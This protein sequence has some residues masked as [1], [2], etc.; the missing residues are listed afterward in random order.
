MFYKSNKMEDKK[1][2]IDSKEHLLDALDASGNADE[3]LKK[4]L[5]D[6]DNIQDIR[7]LQDCRKCFIREDSSLG[8]EPE[9][10]W[11][12]FLRKQKKNSKRVS[13]RLWVAV[14]V[15]VACFVLIWSGLR[16]YVFSESEG[17]RQE[18]VAYSPD[19][20]SVEVML[21]T[22]SGR[23]II[24]SNSRMDSLLK[25]S[26]KVLC[27]EKILTYKNEK[28]VADPEIHTL[29][30]YGGSF[31]QFCLSDGTCVWLNAGSRLIYPSFF[32][33]DQ[34][35]VELYGEG[36]FR[37]A[38]DTLRPFRVKSGN[39]VTEVLGTE[40]NLRSYLREDTHVTLLQG[41]VKVKNESSS[42]EVVIRPGEDAFL[43]ENGSFE[44]KKVDTDN[45][46]LWTKG[47]FYFDNESMLNV[48]RELGRWYNVKVVFRNNSMM[49]LKLHFWAQRDQ[50]IEK[51]LELL[52]S[53]SYAKVTY[54]ERTIFVD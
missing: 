34:R 26:G 29:T 28:Q 45:Y 6:P 42:E 40:F 32:K 38:C 23:Q 35:E 22:S 52:N 17:R 44:V 50:P 41:S 4:L 36:F 11:E 27:Q 8:G 46:S 39:I 18:F 2:N 7:L 31:Y 13:S 3:D 19:S 21:S 5:S 43:L 48:M 1:Q 16:Y 49:D 37:V 47:Y 14:A 53:V 20:T 9:V 33:G 15:A 51:A 30:T 10:A 24:L 54:G 12:N 25:N